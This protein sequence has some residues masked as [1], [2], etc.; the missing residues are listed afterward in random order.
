MATSK[1]SVDRV[2][3][4]TPASINEKTESDTWTRAPHYRN[5]PVSEISRRIRELEREWDIERYL[6]VNMSTLVLIGL[7]TAA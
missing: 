7:A 4:A 1:Q 6:G 2:Q 3:E 5:K